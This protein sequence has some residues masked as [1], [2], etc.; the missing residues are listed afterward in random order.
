MKEIT[1][2]ALATAGRGGFSLASLGQGVSHA[3]GKV[4]QNKQRFAFCFA[5]KLSLS[6]EVEVHSFS[7]GET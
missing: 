1:Y 4:E 7:P 5:P 6:Q 2:L 3:A